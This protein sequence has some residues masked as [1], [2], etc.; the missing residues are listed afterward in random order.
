MKSRPVVEYC[1]LHTL[2]VYREKGIVPP[3][4][5]PL[6]IE[7][8]P[9]DVLLPVGRV[10]AIVGPTIV[11]QVCFLRLLRPLGRSDLHSLA[12]AS[13]IWHEGV[14]QLY[15][16]PYSHRAAGS[17]CRFPHPVQAMLSSVIQPAG[18]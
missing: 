16:L 12:N 18:P 10:S 6:D 7:M 9:D 1:A 11:V 4:V 3:A 5:E 17:C 15:R 13:L 2:W 8:L 14:G